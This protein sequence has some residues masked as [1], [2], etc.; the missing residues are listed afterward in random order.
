MANLHR[1][2]PS[3][4]TDLPPRSP[5]LFGLRTPP[6]CPASPLMGPLGLAHGSNPGTALGGGPSSTPLAGSGT[7]TPVRGGGGGSRCVSTAAL[8]LDVLPPPSSHVLSNLV[9]AVYES[10]FTAAQCYSA[11]PGRAPQPGLARLPAAP[12]LVGGLVDASA[13]NLNAAAATPEAAAAGIPLANAPSLTH[14]RFKPMGVSGGGAGAA[15]AG[16]SGEAGLVLSDIDDL[17]WGL[18]SCLATPMDPGPGLDRRLA[19]IPAGATT[20]TATA[21]RNAA[22]AQGAVN[23][24]HGANDILNDASR[25]GDWVRRTRRRRKLEVMQGA[26]AEISGAGGG[27]SPVLGRLLDDTLLPTTSTHTHAS[28]GGGA[29]Q[30]GGGRQRS[31]RGGAAAGGAAAAS[32]GRGGSR[33]GAL[34]PAGAVPLAAVAAAAIAAAPP[35][36]DSAPAAGAGTSGGDGGADDSPSRQAGAGAAAAAA[37]AAGHVAVHRPQVMVAAFSAVAELGEQEWELEVAEQQEAAAAAG[38]AQAPGGWQWSWPGQPARAAAGTGAGAGAAGAQ[39]V[40]ASSSG[41]LGSGQAEEGGAGEGE[42]EEEQPYDGVHDYDYEYG[43]DDDD[44]VF[45][46]GDNG[47]LGFRDDMALLG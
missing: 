44:D 29:R 18:A 19:P 24:L 35:A 36:A 9:G 15:A 23:K 32:V 7:S 37:A 10:N 25:Y 21:A 30:S 41:P 17:N 8:P 6:T 1:R 28:S 14:G 20:G 47:F 26:L 33:G 13:A 31:S 5:S 42:G 40:S 2:T 4:A 27:G 3:A 46:L 22:A 11:Y 38:G 12:P 45:G 43:G 39:P 16:L 34:V